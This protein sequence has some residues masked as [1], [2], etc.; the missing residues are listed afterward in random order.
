MAKDYSR[1]VGPFD[2]KRRAQTGIYYKTSIFRHSKD[3]CQCPKFKYFSVGGRQITRK[4]CYRTCPT[5][6]YADRFLFNIFSCAKK[7]RRTKASYKFETPQQV[8]TETAFQNG[9]FKQSPES[10][11]ERRLG[12]FNRSER[13][14][15]TYTPSCSS[16]KVSSLLHSRESVPIHMSLFRSLPGAKKFHKDSDGHSSLPQNAEPEI[17]CLSGRLVPSK[18]DQTVTYQRQNKNSQSPLRT[19]FLD[20]SGEIGSST[21]SEHNLHRSIFPIRKGLSVSNSRENS[22]NIS[23]NSAPETGTN[24]SKFSTSFRPYGF[25]HRDSTSCSVIHEASTTPSVALLETNFSG[26]PDQNSNQ[27]FSCRP[28]KMVE[29]ERKFSRGKAIC[30]IGM[31]KST[32]NRCF[33]DRFWKPYEQSKFSRSL[34]RTGENFAHKLS[35]VGSRASVNT[36]F[37]STA[38]RPKC[39]DKIRLNDR[40]TVYKQTRGDTLSTSLLPDLEVMEHSNQ[41]QNLVKGSPFSRSPERSGRPIIESGNTSDRMVFRQSDSP[42]NFPYMGHSNDRFVCNRT[43]SQASNVLF[44]AAE[45][46]S[47]CHRRSVDSVGKHDSICFSTHNTHSESASAYE[48]ISLPTNSDCS[49]M[50]QK[51]LVYGSPSDVDRFSNEA[52]N[53]AELAQPTGNQNLPSKSSS[54]QSSC[55]AAINRS[56]E[57]KGFSEQS[58]KLL[59]ASWRSGTQKDYAAKFK[60]FNSWCSEREIDPYKATLKECVDFLTFLFQSGLK[61]RTIAGYRSMLSAFLRPV[62]NFSVG[63]H[64]DV[65]RLLKGVFNSRPPQKKLVP[66]WDL[67]IVLDFLAGNVFEPLSKVHLKYLTWKTVFLIAVTTFRRCG[68]IQALRVDDGFMSVV[69]EGVIFIREGLAKQDRPGHVGTKILVPSFRK[70]CKLDPKRVLQIYMN[71]TSKLRKVNNL[72]ISYQKPHGSV[73]KQ[74]ISSWIV[75]VVKQAYDNSDLKINAHSTRAIG[76]SWALFKGASLASILEAADWSKDSVFKRFYYRQLDTHNWEF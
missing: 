50:A 37:S 71:R 28:F 57:S 34:V 56:F 8:S 7:V 58:R 65:V 59:A 36:T 20:Q 2:N 44:M 13:C 46:V 42:E 41:K 45:P 38:H 69:P 55:M 29:K 47:I 4:R 64:P 60:K 52:T 23:S 18:P 62:D 73:S 26:S 43:K 10:S 30:P 6:K 63:Q 11:S 76:P 48:E 19:R 12:N 16:Q 53:T 61:Y 74:T 5:R 35:R 33:K 17:S 51:E 22:K 1:S 40:S 15:F 31:L 72:F 66:E 32:D 24:S 21:Q 14:L 9:L 67:K 25:M 39:V 3:K 27:Q 49:T 70:N 75:N 54:V 68:D